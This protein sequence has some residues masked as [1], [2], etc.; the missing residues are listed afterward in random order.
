MKCSFLSP[1]PPPSGLNKYPPPT[2]WEMPPA[3]RGPLF[4]G[5]CPGLG[6]GPGPPSLPR[7]THA[8]G[9]P[10]CP[11]CWEEG[12][13]QRLAAP[14]LTGLGDT[15][16]ATL[17]ALHGFWPLSPSPTTLLPLFSHLWELL[18]G[19]VHPVPTVS[20]PGTPPPAQPQAAHMGS[21]TSSCPR[22]GHP[23]MLI[24]C[25]QHPW[26]PAG[27]GAPA[28]SPSQEPNRKTPREKFVGFAETG[29]PPPPVT[30][31]LAFHLHPKS[32]VNYTL[33]RESLQGVAFWG[34]KLVE[35]PP[36]TSQ[37]TPM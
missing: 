14:L 37:T 4:P 23:Q 8:D 19:Q 15:P 2:S 3:S 5:F 36:L 11:G 33:G 22:W 1:P 32:H 7:D 30:H 35:K 16:R 25:I 21:A 6:K 10:R 28:A 26:D 9:V 18:T 13:W 17:V 24:C 12:R 29:C 31:H 20:P 34:K 27:R